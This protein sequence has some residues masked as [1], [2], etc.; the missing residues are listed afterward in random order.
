MDFG[1]TAHCLHFT[2]LDVDCPL[3][4]GMPFLRDCNPIVDWKARSVSF[5]GFIAPVLPVGNS[6]A[7]LETD[8]NLP[9]IVPSEDTSCIP[10][11]TAP[12]PAREPQLTEHA[13]VVAVDSAAATCHATCDTPGDMATT[14]PSGSP[15]SLLHLGCRALLLLPFV[16]HKVPHLLLL[17]CLSTLITTP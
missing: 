16:A 4:L 9:G 15:P 5:G 7:T 1:T 8:V 11:T 14:V 13:S 3:V 6:F 10:S 12:L 2:V 17:H